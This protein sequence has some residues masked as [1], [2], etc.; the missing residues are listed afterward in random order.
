MNKPK[1]A[2]MTF[3]DAREHEWN[4]LFRGL[5]EP[6]HERIIEYLKNLPVNFIPSLKLLARKIK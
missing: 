5:T 2:L 3:G 1:V 6:R 4:N